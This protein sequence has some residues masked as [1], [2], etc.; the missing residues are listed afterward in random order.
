MKC[1]DWLLSPAHDWV[2]WAYEGEIDTSA[3]PPTQSYAD[4]GILCFYFCRVGGSRDALSFCIWFSWVVGYLHSTT[5]RKAQ[6]TWYYISRAKTCVLLKWC[7]N[8]LQEV[9]LSVWFMAILFVF[10]LKKF[11]PLLCA[12]CYRL[13]HS[14]TCTDCQSS[15]AVMFIYTSESK[16]EANSQEISSRHWEFNSQEQ[17]C[18]RLRGADIII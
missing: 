11:K 4:S 1:L 9:F 8:F 6:G 13:S 16:P 15:P 12:H 2:S 5:N 10:F 14:H 7:L 18:S 17:G 3:P